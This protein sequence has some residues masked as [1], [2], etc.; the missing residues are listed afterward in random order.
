MLAN[1]RDLG[2]L[3]TT[4]GELTRYGVLLRSDAPVLG[5]PVPA[6]LPTWPPGTVV[7]LR[8]DTETAGVS[9]PLDSPDT[10]VLQVPVL[11]DVA[12]PQ[13][14]DT[15]LDVTKTNEGLLSGERYVRMIAGHRAP[16]F[17]PILT[18]AADA[19][20]PLLVHCAAGKDRTGVAVALLLLAAGVQREAVEV[21]FVLTEQNLPGIEARL[22]L[23]SKVPLIGVDEQGKVLP[24][25]LVA[26]RRL[27]DAIEAVDG[28]IVGWW[29]A[30]GAS[31]ELLDRWRS[32]FV[33]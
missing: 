25:T 15:D 14:P 13:Y 24:P 9:H 2:G 20:S 7:D 5:D 16:R 30:A 23:H 12:R 11:R 3:P 32:R 8:G 31:P 18:A 1:I 22:R 21:D 33:G 29:T 19:A 6:E 26:I 28:G 10:V 17:L 27:V 4:G